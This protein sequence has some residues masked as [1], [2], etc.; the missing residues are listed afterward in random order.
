MLDMFV[1]NLFQTMSRTVVVGAQWGDEGKGKI[2]DE[3]ASQACMITRFN[4]G[5]NAGHTLWVGDRK[6]VIHIL[7]SGIVR[8]DTVNLS[9][10]GVI[11]DLETVRDEL[12]IAK[13]H[14]AE[15]VLDHSASVV[16]P[17]HKEIDGARE[18]N[19][20]KAIGTTKR[21]IGPCYED[22]ASRRGV[23][24]GHLVSADTLRSALVDN[25]YYKERTEVLRHHGV[26]ASSVD[27]LVEWCMQFQQN[28][29]PHLGD[30]RSIINRAQDDTIPQLFEG[31]QGVMLD[32]GHG[33]Y[34]YC[35]SSYCTLGG[36]SASF[37][38]YDF[39][40]VLGVAKAYVT[41]VGSGPFPTEDMGED[42]NFLRERGHEFG[43]TTGRPRRCGWLDLVA[44]RYAIRVG[45]IRELALTKLDILRGM[46]QIKVCVGYK[47]QGRLLSPDESLTHHVLENATPVYQTLP[48]WEEDISWCKTKKD[49]PENAQNYVQFVEKF[50]KVP[51]TILGVGP[52]R[53]E[54][55]WK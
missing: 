37:G 31:A 18:T 4:G 19:S 45:G 3:L 8:S 30:T 16:L 38:L 40:R 13:D 24:L 23:K 12:K 53:N 47:F 39:H 22:A 51:V 5:G 33:S 28:I 43:A 11:H 7:P 1:L 29:V 6:Y 21:G 42:G 25:G 48:G 50:T 9:G 27:E 44:L 49:L 32:I 2:V 36:L 10:P 34:P 26:E 54:I 35:T 17:L 52:A 20:Q 46:P 55:I 14:G 41:R 15:V